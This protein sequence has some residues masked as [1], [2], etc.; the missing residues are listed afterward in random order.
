M[1]NRSSSSLISPLPSEPSI[2][3]PSW[4]TIRRPS[5]DTILNS[6]SL[7]LGPRLR[8][9]RAR[10]SRPPT[11]W[12]KLSCPRGR[13]VFS[14][15]RSCCR[16]RPAGGDSL[17]VSRD[18]AAPAP[19]LGLSSACLNCTQRCRCVKNLVWCPA[20]HG[21]PHA[22]K[23][24]IWRVFTSDWDRFGAYRRLKEGCLRAGRP[25]PRVRLL[26]FIDSAR[27]MGQLNESARRAK[28]K[29]L[30]SLPKS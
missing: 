4:D 6:P 9:K 25:P 26:E 28:P 8:G 18:E 10:P 23:S 21:V 22:R 29:K 16:G 11:R 20:R 12:T 17:A 1:P 5:G 15:R 2:I 7:G 19:P 27:R 24:S 30:P 3:M 14:C 13:P